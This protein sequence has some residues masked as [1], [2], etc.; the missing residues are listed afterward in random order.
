MRSVGRGM[1]LRLSC[2]NELMHDMKQNVAS[3]MMR[4]K[5]IGSTIGG[6]NADDLCF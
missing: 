6:D 4:Q 3:R 5:H 1:Q 2:R